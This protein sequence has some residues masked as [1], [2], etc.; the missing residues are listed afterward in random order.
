MSKRIRTQDKDADF[1]LYVQS[2]RVQRFEYGWRI[3]MEVPMFGTVALGTFETVK[4]AAEEVQD[5][6]LSQE[7]TYQI[8]GYS[9]GSGAFEW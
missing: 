8:G 3:V 4:E 1:K 6:I 5:A 2:I 7:E 9:N